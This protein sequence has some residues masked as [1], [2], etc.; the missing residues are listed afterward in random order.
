MRRLSFRRE[1]GSVGLFSVL[2]LLALAGCRSES[3]Q[4]MFAAPRA[5]IDLSP[6]LGEDAPVR[7]VGRKFLKDFGLPE[8]TVFHHTV[9]EEPMY[10]ADSKLELFNHVGPH[11]D[12]P[13]HV[14][15]GARA[16]DS[17]SLD[18]FIGVAKVLDFRSKPKD[19]PLTRADFEGRGL[20][21]GDVVIAYVGYTAPTGPDE[22]PSYAY[23]SGEAAEYL[24]TLPVRLFATDMPSLAGLK[25]LAA[26]MAKGELKG[27]KDLAPEHYA[28][29][30]HEIPSI[31]GL[32]NLEQIVNEPHVVF[33]GFPLK[34]KDGNAGPIRAAALV[35]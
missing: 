31:E 7:S 11:H 23:L 16:T 8:A 29:A 20:V 35:Y 19:T 26:L 9:S 32:V 25:N 21:A 6:T 10:F 12:A 2:S 14:I 30:S 17:F 27:T 15:K 1:V 33:V 3:A 18:Q 34:I 22:Y 28:F 4:P 24:A 5:V 13:S